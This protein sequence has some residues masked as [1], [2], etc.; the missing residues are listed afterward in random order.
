MI[1]DFHLSEL[2]NNFNAFREALTREPKQQEQ[3]NHLKHQ[4]IK[5]INNASQPFLLKL[6]LERK[7]SKRKEE[8]STPQNTHNASS[9]L[10]GQDNDSTTTRTITQ[11]LPDHMHQSTHQPA[12]SQGV[13][14]RS[15]STPPQVQTHSLNS[16]RHQQL[17][18]V[19]ITITTNS[20][21]SLHSIHPATHQSKKRP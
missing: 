7:V 19:L 9:F 17:A 1:T 12:C 15:Q 10:R 16:S 20:P 2:D 4:L 5:S 18:K 8:N 21:P 11:R 3:L 6:K 13:P 14:H